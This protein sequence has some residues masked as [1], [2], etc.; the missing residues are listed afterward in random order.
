MHAAAKEI[1]I[2]IISASACNN[3]TY[4]LE[5]K[6]NISYRYL[7]SCICV[8]VC[9]SQCTEENPQ[10]PLKIPPLSKQNKSSTHI[11]YRKLVAQPWNTVQSRGVA[12]RVTDDLD[13][14]SKHFDFDRKKQT[15]TKT[16]KQLES[17]A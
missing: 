15:T 7:Y 10:K 12:R 13:R 5:Q 14:M 2:I 16:F 1:K 11:R 9:V 17:E 8:G 3:G 6:E 4:N